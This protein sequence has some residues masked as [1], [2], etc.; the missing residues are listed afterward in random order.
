MATGSSIALQLFQ[1]A[2]FELFPELPGKLFVER[3]RL[4]VPKVE[5]EPVD[6]DHFIARYM[7]AANRVDQFRYQGL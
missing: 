1:Q 6:P 2:G 5:V 7:P 4:Q 3:R